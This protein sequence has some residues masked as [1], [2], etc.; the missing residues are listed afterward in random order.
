M[1]P[2]YLKKTKTY[3]I[4]M[5]FPKL[6][7]SKWFSHIIITILS[8]IFPNSQCFSHGLSQSRLA[9]SPPSARVVP[10]QPHRRA[11]APRHPGAWAGGCPG[12]GWFSWKSH[13]KSYCF[14][15]ILLDFYGFLWMFIDFNWF[16]MDDLGVSPWLG[17][18]PHGRNVKWL[19]S[20]GVA[21]LFNQ[22]MVVE[23]GSWHF[24]FYAVK[25]C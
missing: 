25:A 6:G 15:W 19:N 8:S 17:K 1:I 21:C 3:K 10:V 20:L 5:V 22:F 4:P 11:R 18:P 14:L 16:F 2:Q 23:H 9:S 24:M 7:F 12:N 13:G